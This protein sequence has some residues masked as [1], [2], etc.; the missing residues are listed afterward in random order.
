I[1]NYRFTNCSYYENTNNLTV[2]I[3]DGNEYKNDY[4]YSQQVMLYV[5][6]SGDS[7]IYSDHVWINST[8][9]IVIPLVDIPYNVRLEYG[10]DVIAQLGDENI[11][12]IES[13]VDVSLVDVS[14]VDEEIGII[15]GFDVSLLLIFFVVPLIYLIYKLKI[16][17]KRNSK[18]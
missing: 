12:Y 14:P 6:D 15:F 3:A 5:Y 2:I 9:T 17:Q 8:T 13:L 16:K 11:T 18:N 7:I 10:Q 4:N 1:P